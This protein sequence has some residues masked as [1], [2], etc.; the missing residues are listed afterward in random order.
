MTTFKEY[1]NMDL[2]IQID[3]GLD[4]DLNDFC[5]VLQY[6]DEPSDDD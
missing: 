5:E 4:E 3:D 2:E 6:F 1:N